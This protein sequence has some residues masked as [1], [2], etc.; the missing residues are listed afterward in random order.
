MSTPWVTLGIAAA[1]LVAAPASA[2]A[3]QAD[4]RG[5][6]DRFDGVPTHEGSQGAGWRAVFRE[7]VPGRVNYRVC[8]RHRG[9]GEQRCWRRTTGARGRSRV[10][11]ARFVNDRGGPGRWRAVWRVDGERVARWSFRVRPE[12][13]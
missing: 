2:G 5:F 11:V 12:F 3:A 4:F 8:L 9:N 1:L 6:I 13:G 7:R 10:F